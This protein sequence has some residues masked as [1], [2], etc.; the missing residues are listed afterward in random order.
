MKFSTAALSIFFTT[1]TVAAF[2]NT[3]VL[4]SRR[5]AFLAHQHHGMKNGVFMSSTV[6]EK[7]KQAETYE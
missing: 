4:S 5:A 6:V 2:T 7:E 1:A 3:P